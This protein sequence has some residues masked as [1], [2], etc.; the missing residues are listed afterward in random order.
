MAFG[1]GVIDDDDVNDDEAWMVRLLGPRA[2][3]VG[4]KIWRLGARRREDRRNR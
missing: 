2:V 1:T 3:L 4:S